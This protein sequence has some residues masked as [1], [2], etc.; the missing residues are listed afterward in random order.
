MAYSVYNPDDWDVE[1][2]GY[3]ITS[4]GEDGVTWEKAEANGEMKRGIGKHEGIW[5]QSN[6]T[7]YNLTVSVLANCPQLK[8]IIP[9]FKRTT[10]FAV[11]AVNKK[12]GLSFSGTMAMFEEEPSFE[13]GAEAGDIELTMV[14]FDG[15]TASV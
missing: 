3:T 7:T 12:L 9:L 10:P 1:I 8:Y 2:N 15:V 5:Q 4:I 11:S 14:V 6:D 13:M